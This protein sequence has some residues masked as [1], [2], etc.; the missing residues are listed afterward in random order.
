MQRSSSSAKPRES[1][2][3]ASN[4][5]T[6]DSDSEVSDEETHKSS[7][8][9]AKAGTRIILTMELKDKFEQYFRQRSNHRE[10]QRW[11]RLNRDKVG[12]LDGNMK[13]VA[14]LTKLC[15]ILGSAG[16]Q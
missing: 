16:L 13:I 6:L 4:T 7:A 3:T 2:A 5:I 15:F 9:A 1:T 14:R 11:L 12:Y 8:T 10:R